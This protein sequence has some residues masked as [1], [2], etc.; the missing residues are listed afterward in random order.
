[1]IYRYSDNKFQLEAKM[2]K[3][4]PFIE[5]LA[6]SFAGMK[7]KYFYIISQENDSVKKYICV[8]V[9]NLESKEIWELKE[10]RQVTPVKCFKEFVPCNGNLLAVGIEE[11]NKWRYGNRPTSKRLVL[12][13][14]KFT[15]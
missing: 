9:Y 11:K 7:G 14:I 4:I 12:T 10:M 5:Y 1:M 8:Y 2:K 15:Y 13:R 3:E 6:F